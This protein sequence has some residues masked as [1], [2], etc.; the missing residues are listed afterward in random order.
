MQLIRQLMAESAVLATA[1]G[2][3]GLLNRRL[4]VEALLRLLPEE[5]CADEPVRSA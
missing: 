5:G 4:D 3:A 2:L 1:G